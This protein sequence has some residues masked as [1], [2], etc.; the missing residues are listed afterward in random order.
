MTDG[1]CIGFSFREATTPPSNEE[2]NSIPSKKRNRLSAEDKKAK[3]EAVAADYSAGHPMLAIMLRHHLSKPQLNDMLT[4]LFM[5][6]RLTPVTP[7][8]EVVAVSRQIKTLPSFADGSVKFVRI[9]KSEYGINLTP[10][11]DGGE[12]GRN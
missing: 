12:N 4:H 3:L 11:N 6:K 10:Y 1:Q 9:E 8:Y 5:I 2:V 7:S